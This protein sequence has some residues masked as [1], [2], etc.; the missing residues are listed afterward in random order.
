MMARTTSTLR[1][2]SSVLLVILTVFITVLIIVEAKRYSLLKES[3]KEIQSKNET[4]ETKEE[5][6]ATFG[7]KF[8]PAPLLSE[9]LLTPN[10]IPQAKLI[11]PKTIQ[12]DVIIFGD[13]EKPPNDSP[14]TDNVQDPVVPK[15]L[16]QFEKSE[17]LK[18]Q[19]PTVSKQ[20]ALPGNQLTIQKE[21]TEQPMHSEQVWTEPS[22]S[23]DSS[24]QEPDISQSEEP[25]AIEMPKK[26][27]EAK[28][29][30][31]KEP[32]IKL[33]DIN[34]PL[35]IKTEEP[36]INDS[37]QNG[38][39]S[40]SQEIGPPSQGYR[41]P[42]V[43]PPPPKTIDKDSKQLK[44]A[45]QLS[46]EDQIKGISLKKPHTNAQDQSTKAADQNSDLKQ[47]LQNIRKDLEGDEEYESEWR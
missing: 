21:E 6:K 14:K 38:L 47:A 1:I 20:I 18:S 15:K 46:L 35:T 10:Q 11:D 34:I 43:P 9:L 2:V 27:S 41:P 37:D 26:P 30:I 40:D 28:Q 5:R 17:E 32:K 23:I 19:T 16:V 24:I 33:P 13:L 44:K 36:T 22:S 3:K 29:K 42:P 39:I 31:D 8:K 7:P 12:E 4:E 25:L 45:G